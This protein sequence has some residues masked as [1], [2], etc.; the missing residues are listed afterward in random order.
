VELVPIALAIGAVV[1]ARRRDRGSLRS[2]VDVVQVQT[3]S[4]RMR[5]PELVAAAVEAAGGR[6]F[7]A[8]DGMLYGALRGTA[9]VFARQPDGIFEVHVDRKVQPAE[10]LDL[11]TVVDRS[12]GAQVQQ[13]TYRHVTDYAGDH[14]FALESEYVDDDDNIVLTL[15]VGGPR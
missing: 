2:S 13:Q 1:A 4:S 12:Y 15:V 14:G 3:F 7:G 6:M 10:A 9:L 11:V 8:R 5:D